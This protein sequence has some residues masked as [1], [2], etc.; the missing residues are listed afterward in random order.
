MT[1]VP[2]I[3]AVSPWDGKDVAEETF[4]EIDLS[5]LDDIELD[6]GKTEL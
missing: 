4:E 3:S 1:D 6:E 2:S 5:S